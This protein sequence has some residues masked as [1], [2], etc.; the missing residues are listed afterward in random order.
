MQIDL[1]APYLRRHAARYLHPTFGSSSI[2]RVASYLNMLLPG[3]QT[4]PPEVRQQVVAIL[5]KVK[6]ELSEALD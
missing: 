6:P 1:N 3:Q 2:W 4:V 5:E